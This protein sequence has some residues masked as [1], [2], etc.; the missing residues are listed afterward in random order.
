MQYNF[1]NKDYSES[2][3]CLIKNLKMTETQINLLTAILNAVYTKG[4]L[5]Q[6]KNDYKVLSKYE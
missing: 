3:N 1:D 2:I 5:D 6:L 4:L